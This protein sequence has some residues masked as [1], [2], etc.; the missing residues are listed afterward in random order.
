MKDVNDVKDVKDVKVLKDV[1]ICKIGRAKN[2]RIEG[3][4]NQ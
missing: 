4:K 2:P 1:K 3:S